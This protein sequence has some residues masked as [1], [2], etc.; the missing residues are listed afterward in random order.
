MD[1]LIPGDHTG[2]HPSLGNSDE[3][4]ANYF[5][6]PSPTTPQLLCD[7]GQTSLIKGIVLVHVAAAVKTDTH[8]FSPLPQYKSLNSL[9]ILEPSSELK[10]SVTQGLHLLMANP[11]MSDF[12]VTD[13]S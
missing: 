7:L 1:T 5:E 3:E 11:S 10:A 2:T 13:A 9:L 12:L 4:I 6:R 8:V